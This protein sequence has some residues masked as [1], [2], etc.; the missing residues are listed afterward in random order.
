[1]EM[2]G[3]SRTLPEIGRIIEVLERDG[4]LELE[5]PTRDEGPWPVL[6]P[7]ETIEEV[8]YDGLFPTRAPNSNGDWDY[9]LW[10][11]PWEPD[12]ASAEEIAAGVGKGVADP[13]L[14]DVW[15]WYQPIHFFG[16]AW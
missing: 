13:P 12:G 7:D 6:E 14:W 3:W 11:D 1:M 9:E 16:P 15:A 4:A 10:G 8:D 5:R 2:R